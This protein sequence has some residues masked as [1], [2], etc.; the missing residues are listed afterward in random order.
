MFFHFFFCSKSNKTTQNNGFSA[1]F[2]PKKKENTPVQEI[3]IQHSTQSS[4][5]VKIFAIFLFLGKSK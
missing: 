5:E 2:F 3:N 1:D 4:N